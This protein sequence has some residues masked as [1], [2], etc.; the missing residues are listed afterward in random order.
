MIQQMRP[1]LCPITLAFAFALPASAVVPIA[2]GP[3]IQPANYFDLEGRTLHFKPARRGYIV[4]SSRVKPGLRL[5]EE[6]DNPDF[7]FIRSWGWKKALPFP[8]PFGGKV[9]REIFVN[10][11]GNLTFEQPEA[12][13]FPE[14]E[15]WP[16]GTMQSVGGSLNDRAAAGQEQMICALWANYMPQKGKTQVFLR[17]SAKEFVVTWKAERYQWFGEGY[18]PLGL[19][20]FEARL[21]PDGSIALSYRKVSEKDGIVGV[22]VGGFYGA[23][24]ATVEGATAE[25]ADGTLRFALEMGQPAP[26]RIYRVVLDEGL[27]TREIGVR[28]KE[29]PETYF[30]QECTGH[31][32][33]RIQGN[34][35]ELFASVFEL[36]NVLRKGVRWRGSVLR[37]LRP[38]EPEETSTELK[39]FPYK[40]DAAPRK[41]ST[42]HGYREG[43]I[44]EVFHYPHVSKQPFPLIRY[45]YEHA[46]A[47]DDLVAILTDFRIDDLHNHQGTRTGF[48][49]AIKGIGAELAMPYD[50]HRVTGSAK[51]QAVT[52]PAYL[53]PRFEE[54]LTE[55][56]RHY[57]NYANAAGWIAHE[58][59]HRWGVA[60][61]FRNPQTGDVED[62]YDDH[63]HWSDYLNTPS[64][65]SVWRMFSDKLYVEKSQMGGSSTTS[66]R[67]VCSFGRCH[68][69][70]LRVDSPRWTCMRWV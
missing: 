4:S 26:G 8:F 42:T 24:L 35:I 44:F 22:F 60:L 29:K 20:V 34:R 6:L 5:G 10:A 64:M 63:G 3:L 43:N 41:L 69:G 16:D 67:S 40:F 56:D 45:I 59:G 2:A 66:S 51:L 57:R 38:G 15:T 53:G 18:T 49:P 39:P 62:L 50:G 33:Y 27:D 21:T 1:S 14:R 52:G 7:K 17:Q 31:P 54:L 23:P 37:E 28:L 47:E 9:R 13:L 19:N 36:Q 12:E 46:P 11:A 68:R 58:F 55:D 70:T 30:A 65:V 25:V 32:G 61:Q 48:A